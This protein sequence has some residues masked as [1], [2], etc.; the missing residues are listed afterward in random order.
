MLYSPSS[1]LS[2]WPQQFEEAPAVQSATDRVLNLE[3][4][5]KQKGWHYL[6]HAIALL[7]DSLQRNKLAWWDQ[8]KGCFQVLL[9]SEV[10]VASRQPSSPGYTV[11]WEQGCCRRAQCCSGGV[12]VPRDRG[13]GAV[14]ARFEKRD[15]EKWITRHLTWAEDLLLSSG[16]VNCFGYSEMQFESLPVACIK[17]NPFFFSFF[18][19]IR[20]CFVQCW[21]TSE[22]LL[23]SLEV[24]VQGGQRG[25]SC[26]IAAFGTSAAIQWGFWETRGL[27][28]CGQLPGY[29][30]C[31]MQGICLKKQD[32]VPLHS[33]GWLFSERFALQSRTFQSPA[34]F[35]SHLLAC[36]I[37]AAFPDGSDNGTELAGPSPWGFKGQPQRCGAEQSQ[38]GGWKNFDFSRKWNDLGSG[39]IRQVYANTARSEMKIE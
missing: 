17:L 13:M 24:W 30:L 11:T 36:R 27:H 15:K 12:Q 10:H 34:F 31:P 29:P 19:K 16:L 2:F 33:L 23:R 8:S 20:D 37:L 5:L 39:W 1:L 6:S 7:R 25:R 26:Q 3:L 4:C 35:R 38:E 18:L 9:P 21:S 28:R 14:L 22:I 32:T